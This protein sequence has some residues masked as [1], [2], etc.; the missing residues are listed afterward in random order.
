[1]KT[2]IQ[3]IIFLNC[4]SAFSQVSIPQP[5]QRYAYF[6]TTLGIGAVSDTFMRNQMKRNTVKTFHADFM[7]GG[8]EKRS[9]HFIGGFNFSMSGGKSEKTA[10]LGYVVDSRT[11][12]FQTES[13]F[14]VYLNNKNLDQNPFF[15]KLSWIH[16]SNDNKFSHYYNEYNGLAIGCGLTKYLEGLKASLFVGMEYQ[17]NRQNRNSIDRNGFMNLDFFQ[18]NVGL[19]L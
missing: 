1:M 14:R 2:I 15:F 4:F 9:V 3:I 19:T 6:T 11:I 16:G 18:F 10:T 12:L 17:T 13:G 8:L 5:K 7:F